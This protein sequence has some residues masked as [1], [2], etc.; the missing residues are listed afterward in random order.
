MNSSTSGSHALAVDDRLTE[1]EREQAHSF[2]NQTRNGMIGAIKGLSGAQWHF[3]PA[4]DRWSIA[5]IAEHAVF[6]LER[7][8]GPMQDILAQAPAPPAD[9]DFRRVDAIVIHQFPTRLAK[10]PTP[11]FALPGSRFGSPSEALPVLVKS[12]SQLSDCLEHT[13][14]LREH[15]LEAPP[16]KALTSGAFDLMDGYQWILA[17]AAHAERHT[18]QILEVKADENFPAN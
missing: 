9:R 1:L 6:V 11:E 2:L 8:G 13:P 5:E 16:L 3:K 7:V 12:Y 18:K 10:F 15:A 4:P 17:A 14:D